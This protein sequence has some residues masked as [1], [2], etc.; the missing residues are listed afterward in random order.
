MGEIRKRGAIW[1]IRYYRNGR[2]YEESAR[3][4]KQD[5]A[6]RLLKQ[7]EGDV[8][9][10]MPITPAIGR[11]TF[12]D[13]AKD[14]LTD[15]QVNGRRS[16][17]HVKRRIEAGL[18]PWF[19]RRRM[20]SISTS[21]VRAYTAHRLEAGAAKATINR[22]LAAL[23]RAFTL[24]MQAGKVLRRPYI[25]LLQEDNTRKGFFERAQFE[26]V[27]AHLPARLQGVATFAYYTGWRTRSEVLT[28]QWHQVD[29]TACTVRLEPGTTKNREGRVFVFKDLTDLR[30]ALERQDADRVRLAKADILS[31][32]VFHRKNGSPIRSF[33]KTWAAACA[34]AG[35]P[36]RI[37]HDFRR[38]AVRNLVRAGVPDTIAMKLTGHKTRAVFDRY[39]ITSE[40]DLAEAGRKLQ[41]LTGTIAGTIVPTTSIVVK[42]FAKKPRGLKQLGHD[43]GGDRTHD[44]VIKSHMLYH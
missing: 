9:H 39:D 6:A 21:D 36:G 26:A 40:E 3:T 5:D 16:Y 11:L 43:P 38:T 33:R 42:A 31:P 1:W 44:P 10:G 24:A 30:D 7:R 20:A 32:W 17:V 19:N 28:L 15:Y 18:G 13:A 41:A 2:R 14:L 29:F 23:K 37:P 22:E 34:K 27:R 8:A 4:T 12:E 35:C 25:P